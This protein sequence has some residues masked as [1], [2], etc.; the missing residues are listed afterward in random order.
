[1][2]LDFTDM[3][4]EEIAAAKASAMADALAPLAPLVYTDVL[5]ITVWEA[6]FD[7]T[8]LGIRATATH[9]GTAVPTDSAYYFVN[10]P[11][12]VIGPDGEPV[13]DVLGAAKE[14]IRDAL[15]LYARS[16]GTTI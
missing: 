8:K 10:P 6:W 7:G 2:P 5:A 1:M 15:V 12:N 16:A 13:E 9:E 11:V 4:S 14:I 3:T